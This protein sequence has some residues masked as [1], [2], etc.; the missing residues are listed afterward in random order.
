MQEQ[1]HTHRAIYL[2][3]YFWPSCQNNS[4]QKGGTFQYEARTT[5]FCVG[6]KKKKKLII[7]LNIEEK[8]L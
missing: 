2:F 1:T 3:I 8:S 6:K 5:G 7:S 4:I